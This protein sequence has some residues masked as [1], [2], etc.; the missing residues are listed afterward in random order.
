[1]CFVFNMIFS[2]FSNNQDIKND[3]ST[4]FMQHPKHIRWMMGSFQLK[5][6]LA[7]VDSLAPHGNVQPKTC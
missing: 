1:M 6:T 2:F 5:P 7:F 4:R 3:Q